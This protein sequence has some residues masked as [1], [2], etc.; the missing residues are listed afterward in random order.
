MGIYLNPGNENFK[1]TLARGNYVDKTSMISVVNRCIDTGNN[2]ICMSRPRRFGKTITGNMLTAYYSKGCD[3][4]ELFAPYKIAEDPDYSD[5][6]GKRNTQ[7]VIKI[8]MNS[9]YQNVLD[10][11]LMIRRL[12]SKIKEEIRSE[13]PGVEIKEDDS[14]AECILRVYAEKGETFII[15]IDE[16]DVLVREQV[17]DSLFNEY[18]SFLN[19]FFKSDTLRPAISLAYLTGILPIVRDK[20]QSKLN[21]FREYTILNAGEMASYIGFTADEVKKLCIKH[22]MDFDECR[23]WYD[24]YHLAGVEIYNPESVIRSMDENSFG[25]YW[26]ATSSYDVIV[27]RI[28]QNFAGTREDVIRMLSGEKVYVDSGMFLNAMNS[29]RTKDDIFTYLCHIGYLAY[30]KD[31]QTCYIPNGEVRQEWTR[32][33]SVTDEYEVTDEIIKASRELLISTVAG[34]EKA[35]SNALD[36]SHI[37]VTSNR[38]YNNE[39]ALQSAIYLAYIYAL[40]EYTVVKEMTTGKGFADVV[41]IPCCPGKENRPAMIIELKHNKSAESAITQIREKRY[42][43]SLSHYTGAL[44]FVGIDYDEKKK[45]H[46][47]RIERFE[48]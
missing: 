30:D 47:C 18:L 42:F 41:Y 43:D 7:N 20:I 17:T 6:N 27:D 37:H 28:R 35:V 5:Q 45:T 32:A 36:V 9:E 11:E 8:D 44:L 22:N 21:N 13:F 48:K 38:S 2:Y 14:L 4:K 12:M 26:S 23:R 16:Y 10:K 24:G 40:N 19:G 39:D 25:N 34:D 3:S 31:T 15:I 46:S 1:K 29:F 33:V